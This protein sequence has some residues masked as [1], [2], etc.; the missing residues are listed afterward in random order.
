MVATWRSSF[1]RLSF[2]LVKQASLIIQS[3]YR[4]CCSRRRLVGN[5]HVTLVRGMGMKGVA[6]PV[7]RVALTVNGGRMSN[8]VSGPAARGGRE[9]EWVPVLGA[10]ALR[11][12][13]SIDREPMGTWGR[14]VCTGG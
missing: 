3:W 9:P 2:L 10:G 12:L 11:L 8:T 6:V 5:V 7:A 1:T 4:G 14:S 13:Y